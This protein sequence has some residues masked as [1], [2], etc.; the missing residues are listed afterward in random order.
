MML[1]RLLRRF[2]RWVYR[3]PAVLR[4]VRKPP[5]P[6][7]SLVVERFEERSGPD[8]IFHPLFGLGLG[9]DFGAAVGR[10]AAPLDGARAIALVASSS[11]AGPQTPIVFFSRPP[12]DDAV[13]PPAG[14]SQPTGFSGSGDADP[15]TSPF[16]PPRPPTGRH[17]G[18]ATESGGGGAGGSGR[19]SGAPG[20]PG[21]AATLPGPA[22]AGGPAPAD[23]L[24]PPPQA[25]GGSAGPA[26]GSPGL[27]G[28]AQ[29][30]GK[31][32]IT[33][34]GLT[35]LSYAQLGNDA[36]PFHYDASPLILTLG[37][38]SMVPVSD[39]TGGGARR[40][41]LNMPLDNT[42]RFVGGGTPTDFVVTGKVTIGA[43]TFDGTLVTGQVRDFG[44]QLTPGDVEFEVEIGITGGALTQG[45]QRY[46][47]V[48]QE[49]GLLIHQPD[50]PVST[51][52]QTF[53]LTSFL[54][55]SD[56]AKLAQ[57]KTNANPL[58]PPCNCTTSDS[59]SSSPGGAAQDTGNG[60]VYLNL[61][62]AVQQVT[63]NAIKGLGML[64]LDW[65]LT[66]TYRSDVKEPGP[67]GQN[68]ELNYDNRLW[69]V[70]D[71]NRAEIQRSFPFAQSG[72][73]VRIDGSNRAD[74]YRHNPDGTYADPKGFFTQLT[75]T[76]GGGFRE[77]DQAGMV[78]T[79]AA[80]DNTGTAAMTSMTDRDG[81]ALHFQYD[82][83]G[84]LTHVVDTMGRTI[85]YHYDGRRLLTDV[86]DFDNRTV[87]YQYDSHAELVAETS[88][89]VT[90]TPT[91][92]D[93]PDGKTTRYTYAE[94][95]PDARLNHELL[96]VTAPNEVATGGPPRVIY[97][98]DTD[99][100]SP[101]I[102]R[103]LSL[104][105]G[106]VNANGVPAGGTTSYTYQTLVTSDPEN[107]AVS[108]FQTTVTDRNGNVTEYQF[109]ELGNILQSKQFTN[110]HVRPGD[111]D[112]FLTQFRYD[113][114]YHLILQIMPQGNTT[115]Y[116]YSLDSGTSTG[117]NTA[118]TLNDTTKTWTPNEWAGQVVTIIGGTGEDD[119][120]VRT[121]TGNTATQL[122]LASPWTT[123]P[124]AIS[125]YEI[126]N[127][128]RFQQNNL[129]STTRTPDAARG[130]DQ[131]SITTTYTYE[132]IYNQVH[133]TTDARGNNANYRPPIILPG[134]TFPD[135]ARYTTVYTYDYQE[136]TNFAGLAQNIGGGITAVQVQARLSQAGVPMG[137]GDV[138]GD[139]RT[140][141]LHGNLIRT[142]EPTVHLL[143]G[144]NEAI[145][146]GT[147]AQPIVTFYTYN[148]Y[149]QVTRTTDPE[150]NVSQSDYY[151][152]TNPSGGS[153]D[154][155]GGG[156]LAQTIQDTTSA[157][158]RDSG[159]NPPPANIRTQYQYDPVGNV[160]RQIDGRGIATDYTYNQLD[161]VVQTTRAAAVPGVSTA[162]PLP[163]TA[164]Q[165]LSRTFYDYNNNVVLTQVEDRGDTSKVQGLPPAGD[166]P[167]FFT[168]QQSTSTGGNT[169][170]TLNDTTQTWTP[171]QY[172]GR[173]VQITGGTGA[174]QV[175][176]ITGNTATQLTLSKPWDSTPDASSTYAI[177]TVRNPTDTYFTDTAYQY[178]ILDRQVEMIQEV[179]TSA[180]PVPEFLRTSYRYDPNANQVLTIQPEGNATATVYDER[181]LMY[182]SIQGAMAPPPLAQL[183]PTD[184]TNY[185]VRGGL[186]STT[187]Y[188][189]DLNRN[190][191]QTVTADDTDSSPANNGKQPSGTS[192]GGNTATTLNDTN[193][194]WMPGQWQGRSVLIVSGTGVGQLRIIASNTATQLTL[195]TPWTITPDSTSVY[196][197]QGDRTRMVYDGFD[198][199]VSTI[200]SV[201]NQTVTQYDPVGNVVRMSHFGPTG[202]ASPTSD[203]P[204]VLPGPVSSL[205]VIQSSNLVNS[206]LLSAT[207]YRF[208]ELSRTYET[209]QVLFVNTIPTVRPA[210]VAEGATDVGLGDLN[211]GDT[212]S[213]AGVS[214]V[215][216]LGRVA[217]RTEYDRDSRGVFTVRDDATTTRTLYDGVSRVIKI[218]DP[219]GNTVET[220]YDADNNVIENRQTDVSQVAGVANEI[221][222]RTDFYDSLNRLQESVDNL[223]QTTYDRY[224]SRD[225]L[226]A[227]A[228][229]NGPPTGTTITRRH[230]ADGPRTVD[231][232]NSF[233]NVTRY[234]YDGLSRKLRDEQ[235]LTALPAGNA[236]S[237]QGDG[238]HIGA[239]IYG[240]KDDL[241]AP[242][243]FTPTPDTSGA[244]GDPD[245]IIRTGYIYDQ[246]SLQSAMIDD[247]GNV[248][249]SV[250]DDLNRRVT[251]TGGLTVNS[252]YTAANFLGPR[253]V[254]TPTAATINDPA[255]IPPAE[256]DAQL[257]EVQSRVMAVAGLFPP[258]AGQIDDHP[259]TTTIYGYDPVGNVLMKS[260][261]NNSY[262]YTLYDAIDRPI[263][264]RIF[265]AGQADS[266]AG[267]P[268]FDPTPVSLPTN[269][270]FDNYSTFPSVVGTTIQNFQ[271]DGL[272]RQTYAFDNNDPTNAAVNTQV[273][274]AYDSLGRL[275]EETQQIGTQPA[276]AIDSAWRGDNLRKSLTYPNGRVETYTY[277]TLD[278]LATVSDQ[279]ASQAIAV[280]RYI[281]ADR[282]LERDYPQNGTRE[283][284]LSGTVDVGYDGL[285]RP[286]Q[287]E[288]LGPGNALIL[289]F[290]YTYD[291][292]NNKLTEG[293]LHDPADSES[294][295]YDS[296]YRL[297]RL[298]R[299]AGGIAPLQSTWA[300]DGVGNPTQVDGESRRYTSFNELTQRSS[301]STTTPIVTDDNGNEVDDGTYLYAYDAM[302]RL[303]TVTRKS[304]G[305]LIAT[306]TYDAIGR[307]DSKVVTN[308]GA[309]NGTTY[310][311]L[312]GW[313]EIE[314]RNASH[315]PTQQYV[316]GSYIDE[317]LVV[318]TNLA[319]TPKQYFYEQNTLYSVY[320][321]TDSMGKVVEG[322]QYDAYGRQTVFYQNGSGVVVFGSG[323]VFTEG[324]TSAVGN[325]FLFTGRRLDAETTR[326]DP[327]TGKQTG[328]YY[329]RARYMDT[330]EGRF[331]SR[332]PIGFRG[333]IDLY[334]YVVSNP[335][336]LVDPTGLGQTV[337]VLTIST[338]DSM[339]RGLPP[340]GTGENVLLEDKDKYSFV[341][342]T[343]QEFYDG[344]MRK[345][346]Q[347]LEEVRKPPRRPPGGRPSGEPSREYQLRGGKDHEM[348]C[349][350]TLIRDGHGYAK[351]GGQEGF[352][353][354]TNTQRGQM[355]S[356]MCEG[357]T[358]FEA[359][360]HGIG[361][362]AFYHE[363]AHLLA[364]HGGTYEGFKGRSIGF[365]PD[366]KSEDPN[367]TE[368]TRVRINK[369]ESLEAVR[370]KIEAAAK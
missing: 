88:P 102:A 319:G 226:V 298:Q 194:A 7:R 363:M 5:R 294:Y 21:G 190:L 216:I 345:Y 144:S 107:L 74:L 314:E 329:Y 342:Y 222:L 255:S 204:D 219:V 105:T 142:Q 109:N 140:D 195:T 292:A 124:D 137:L 116:Q 57:I 78:T 198:R 317:P 325:P 19:G 16:A 157:P 296:A 205:G 70:T 185:D 165:Y 313:Q 77:R 367:E 118:T 343:A 125:I 14:E 351:L 58:T 46:L 129:L 29:I 301:G 1:R 171:N 286:V 212:G 284:Y 41:E 15:W 230:F 187:T 150:G 362:F 112:F 68:W 359:G 203:G 90:G 299:A 188:D 210:D 155:A 227:T 32:D 123:T 45:N 33:S 176:T 271:Y 214:G 290:T 207:E 174:G 306:Y 34:G 340:A 275:I 287:E 295:V 322:Y 146:E 83:I 196:A 252:T 175:R 327:Q 349:I 127:A 192:T 354:L 213:I 308:S 369:G 94:E 191:I 117:G 149:G 303:R 27:I 8:V 200:D 355:Q 75:P 120:Q 328:L 113:E 128:D 273:T 206:N 339:L 338:R 305:I 82:N 193:Q 309:L 307:R 179:G 80:P 181:D 323:G 158:G 243:S 245:G 114:D 208:D 22:P 370:N 223:G 365:I 43:N 333:G 334:E 341:S 173:T 9:L 224:D 145:V 65:S 356:V 84:E 139:G 28:L 237:A 93:F 221:F 6:P 153:I 358:I 100:A 186:P 48:S 136:G 263:A 161:Q 154:P 71:Q 209:D 257:A 168:L 199:A 162:E 311:Y 189:Y 310:F 242:E 164:F 50:L 135:P 364:A 276:Q 166:L 108:V 92:N 60:S 302:N 62:A 138:N 132:P 10:S 217:D 79:Y 274:E 279:G 280:Y 238:V 148:D 332:D 13:R 147:T 69:V 247:N 24:I 20:N 233:G 87:H 246:N 318:D 180:N 288:D 202:G 4:E 235:I 99:P 51:F 336:G 346:R 2:L 267:D 201:G 278:R 126:K 368:R 244:Q 352:E 218:V 167:A 337:T 250:Y 177:L 121:I 73:V 281:G 131:A 3:D 282:V 67:L 86:T 61:G 259:P 169:A 283:T 253:P 72:D 89:A 182:Q 76:P 344:V 321:L 64:G 254:V 47:L 277:D 96:T 160:T 106:G 285:A 66:R 197:F 170:T 239:S 97:S 130:G 258:L 37:D 143:P 347:C 312:D 241:T 178:D 260:D 360:C 42:G 95:Y 26:A 251:E 52:P 353:K 103:V 56:A 152:I 59:P 159:T 133:S 272:S 55:L 215:N 38:G 268:I 232:T 39:P 316:Y 261:E 40:T 248:T 293:K 350:S 44:A 348:C 18:G 229:A 249:V 172:A 357:A 17:S 304:D 300:L 256:I 85:D 151:S 53:A 12:R 330:V 289:G 81:N 54:G 141:Q 236:A 231:A 264:V 134:E 30:A 297:V 91:G 234:F 324:G 361:T 156:Y 184:P 326:T 115:Q 23:L 240:V 63:D 111:P 119:L 331:I 11:S 265:R 291:R 183:A 104:E 122:M 110:R 220:A 25:P 270:S 262:T 266:F 101:D 366:W 315:T 163:L 225:N 35:H 31:P 49:I 36:N 335:V 211:P 320:A 98:Y 269:H 228:D